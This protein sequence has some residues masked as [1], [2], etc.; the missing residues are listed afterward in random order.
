MS[1]KPLAMQAGCQDPR[2]PG[3]LSVEAARQRIIDNLEPMSATLTLALRDAL[4]YTLGEDLISPV[5]VPAHTNSAVDGYALRGAELP[6]DEE[7]AFDCIASAFAGHP[8]DTPVGAG[9]CIRIMTG[10][11]LPAGADTVIM[12][13]Q[14]RVEDDRVWVLRRSRPHERQRSRGEA[15]LEHHD[16]RLGAHA[17]VFLMGAGEI[18]DSN[19][20]TLYG[21][22]RR[23]GVS[24]LDLGVVRDRPQALRDAFQRASEDADVLVTSGGVSVGESDFVKDILDELGTVDFWKIAMK[25]GRPFAFGRLGDCAFFGLPGNPVAVMVTFYQFV[26]PALLHLAGRTPPPTTPLFKARCT[27]E[28]R[29]KPG[30]TEFYRGILEPDGDGTLAVRSA[31]AQGSGV[32]RSMAEAH[33][34]VILPPESGSVSPGALVDVQPFEGLV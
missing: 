28:I 11:P 2:D 26:R 32:L 10:A 29:K 7:R 30:R 9:Q 12:Q 21:M 33:C 18:Y 23:L 14:T 5:D 34:F 1:T 24:I 6:S 16:H 22:L 31:G 20:Y 13:E 17:A 3:T 4:G 8:T 25:P 19:R 27:S 15:P